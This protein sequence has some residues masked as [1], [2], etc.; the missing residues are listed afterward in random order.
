[1]RR[2]FQFMIVAATVILAAGVYVSLGSWKTW[3]L[4]SPL[5]VSVIWADVAP[6]SST[7]EAEARR[8]VDPTDRSVVISRTEADFGVVPVGE[9]SREIPFTVTNGG[10]VPL[11]LRGIHSRTGA[12]VVARGPNLPARIGSG[13]RVTVSL[14]FSPRELGPVNDVVEISTNAS[15]GPVTIPVRGQG[16][17]SIAPVHLVGKPRVQEREAGHMARKL[18][19][20]EE[21]DKGHVE[22][23]ARDPESSKPSG[24]ITIGVSPMPGTIATGTVATNMPLPSWL[25]SEPFRKSV[26][27]VRLAVQRLRETRNQIIR[28]EW[29]VVNPTG[30]PLSYSLYYER[31]GERVLL[32]SGLS[33]QSTD[34]DLASLAGGRIIVQ[35]TDGSF[36]SEDS[37]SLASSE[38]HGG[39]S[40]TLDPRLRH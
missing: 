36:T 29:E 31:E 11:E 6:T 32:M 14:I 15:N 19:Q 3:I 24:I 39:G 30:R 33:G 37:I 40:T 23:P 10:S 8:K 22:V 12:F 34:L 38:T 27:Y 18:T 26:P 2:Q 1:M 20:K 9:T 16:I 25:D 7:S 17:A 4:L 28:C 5:K 35:A 21:G 13:V